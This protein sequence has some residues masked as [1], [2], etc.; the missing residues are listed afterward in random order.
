M[1]WI[2]SM[3]S[4]ARCAAIDEVRAVAK[5]SAREAWVAVKCLSMGDERV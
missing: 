3:L 1:L 5:K 2:P 4:V